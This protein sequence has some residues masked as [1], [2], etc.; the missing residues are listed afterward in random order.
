MSHEEILESI[1]KNTILG[2]VDEA[3]EGFEG[4][5]EG[6]PGVTELVES[7]LEQGIPVSQIIAEALSPAMDEVGAKYESKEYLIPDMLAGAECV[8]AAMDI[9]KPHLEGSDVERKGTV[10]IASVEGDRHDIGKN[11]VS[12]LLK[13]AGYDVLD[14]GTSV[15]ADT[16]VEELKKSEARFVGLSALLTSTMTKMP[17]V[18]DAIKGAGLRDKVSVIV[19][20]APVNQE[21]ADKIGADAYC[22]DAFEAVDRLDN[23]RSAAG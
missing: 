5:M 15:P 23:L 12:T 9:L 21:F 17:E 18:I 3:D 6:E 1:R 2:R 22:R 8:S 20:G 16:I 10:V 7:A 13:G 4:D 19:G 11:I 14:L